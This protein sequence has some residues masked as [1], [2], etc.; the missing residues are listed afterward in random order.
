MD[1]KILSWISGEGS[2]ELYFYKTE[3][4]LTSINNYDIII[5]GGLE[6]WED[7]QKI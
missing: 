5:I 6:I 1:I 2:I 4:D 7:Q 3:E